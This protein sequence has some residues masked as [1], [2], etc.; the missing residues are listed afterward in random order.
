MKKNFMIDRSSENPQR[1]VKCLN[2]IA[3]GGAARRQKAV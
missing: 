3:E 2:L 1:W